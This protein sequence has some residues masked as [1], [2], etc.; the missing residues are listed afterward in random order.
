MLLIFRKKLDYVVKWF[1]ICN[2]PFCIL[3]EFV[4]GGDLETYLRKTIITKKK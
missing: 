4:N 3:T 2:Q 1:G